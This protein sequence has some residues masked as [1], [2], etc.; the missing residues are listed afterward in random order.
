MALREREKE[1]ESW[2]DI[3]KG[4]KNET[5]IYKCKDKVRWSYDKKREG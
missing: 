2:R 3:M 4:R 5:V 1:K